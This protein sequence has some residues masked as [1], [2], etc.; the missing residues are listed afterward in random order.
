MKFLKGGRFVASGR[1][2]FTP[3]RWKNPVAKRGGEWTCFITR[4]CRITTEISFPGIKIS[5]LCLAFFLQ[6]GDCRVCH[7]TSYTSYG[8]SS[9]SLSSPLSET[10]LPAFPMVF[11]SFLF[12]EKKDEKRS[13][14]IS[15]TAQL[16]TLSP[17]HSG[18]PVS[19]FW[20][21]RKPADRQ[22]QREEFKKKKAMK[23][24]NI[25]HKISFL[26][27]CCF[28]RYFNAFKVNSRTI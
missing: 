2:G 9:P 15:C 20:H 7:P 11:S 25:I 18:V 5:A 23:A 8:K 6:F 24:G 17:I 12:P 27:G 10:W 22:F 3:K 28:V 16:F 1:S 13:R 14:D 21:V 4:L 26:S 19:T